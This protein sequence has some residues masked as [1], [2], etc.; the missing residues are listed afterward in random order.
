MKAEVIGG[1][2]GGDGNPDPASAAGAAGRHGCA[3]DTYSMY[4]PSMIGAAGRD[5][6]GPAQAHHGRLRAMAHATRLHERAGQWKEVS[7]NKSVIS[8]Q[9]SLVS[10]Q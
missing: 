1:G 5:G 7:E 10:S 4:H 8:S 9:W 2:E 6:C 3:R